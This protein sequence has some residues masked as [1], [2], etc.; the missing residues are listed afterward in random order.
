MVVAPAGSRW[1]K[2]T[3]GN[4]LLERRILLDFRSRPIARVFGTEQL[5][6]ISLRLGRKTLEISQPMKQ[7]RRHDQHVFGLDFQHGVDS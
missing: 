5:A 7:F 4:Q 1:R 2:I 6:Q 3:Y